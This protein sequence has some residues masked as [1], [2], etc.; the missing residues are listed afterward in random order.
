MKNKITQA[1]VRKWFS[2]NKKTGILRWKLSPM[3]RIN[4]GDIA[5]NKNP[6]GYLIVGFKYK[7][8]RVHR[9]IWL[10]M[11]GYLP[12]NEIDHINK[13]KDDNRWK[14]LRE[15]SNQCN[16]RNSKVGNK[17]KSGIK[18]IRPHK[19][20]NKWEV[21]IT[22]NGKKY[23]LGYFNDLD[24]AACHRLAAEQCLNWNKCDSDSSAY[25]HIKKFNKGIT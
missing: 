8:C 17:S 24:E 7:H 5:G 11:K 2:Y 15:V 12:E 25:Q 19:L 4:I 9:L 20:T 21:Y 18:G 23:H 16:Q 1:E 10:G 22:V 3:N 14:N 6:K 13:I